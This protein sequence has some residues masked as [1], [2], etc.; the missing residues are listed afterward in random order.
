[1]KYICSKC[2]KEESEYKAKDLNGKPHCDDCFYALHR[3]NSGE[4]KEVP[5]RDQIIKKIEARIEVINETL[6]QDY[7]SCDR[8]EDKDTEL[9]KISRTHLLGMRDGLTIALEATR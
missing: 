4:T 9:I 7:Y 8:P 6:K 3:K 2:G 5:E 1:M